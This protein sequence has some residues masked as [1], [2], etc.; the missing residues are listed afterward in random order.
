MSSSDDSLKQAWENLQFD[1]S[2]VLLVRL[3]AR[4]QISKHF[5][6]KN[7]S[8]E[9]IHILVKVPSLGECLPY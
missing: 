6:G 2:D 5:R 4:E 8:N 9:P 7:L 3:T 1:G